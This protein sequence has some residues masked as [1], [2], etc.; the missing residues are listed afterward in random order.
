MSWRIHFTDADLERVEIYGTPAPFGETMLAVSFLRCPLQP[1]GLFSAWR[2]RSRAALT[3]ELRPLM[4]LVPPGSRGVDL[5]TLVGD[6]PTIEQGIEAL[7]GIPRADLLAELEFLDRS[8]RLPG[9]AWAVAEVDGQARRQLAAAIEAAYRALVL[10]YWPRIS[11]QL[12]ATAVSWDRA[13]AGGG[14]GRLLASLQDQ[15]I[16][17]RPP[18]LEITGSPQEHELHLGGGGI[19]LAPSVFAGR[20]ASVHFDGRDP[21]APP[22]LRL[23]AAHGM[24]ARDLDAPATGSAGGAALAALIGRTRAAVLRNIDGGCTTTEL[25]GRC[26][27]SLAA[28]SQHA[29]VLRNAGLITT[30]RQGSAVLH[31]LT[32][33]GDDLLRAG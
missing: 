19:A 33:L 29:T 27:I 6:A 2:D 12:R 23:P 24:P 15:R 16:R 4:V 18:V 25:A 8:H 9:P 31:A 30:R 7:L 17:W 11:A 21:A 10:P 32:E 5:H 28:A 3:A 14:P 26:G 1:G 22:T 13:L 20:V